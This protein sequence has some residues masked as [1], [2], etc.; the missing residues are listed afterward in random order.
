MA[1]HDVLWRL[2]TKTGWPVGVRDMHFRVGSNGKLLGVLLISRGTITWRPRF[3]R[4]GQELQLSWEDFDSIMQD[5][6]RQRW[7]PTAQDE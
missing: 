5:A 2:P 1:E 4:R 7:R 6:G 3:R